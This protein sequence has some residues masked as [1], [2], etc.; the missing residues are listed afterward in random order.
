M[1]AKESAPGH[2]FLSYVREDLH[3]VDALQRVLEAAQIRVWRDT[4]DLWPGQDWRREIR[5]A[6]TD[7]ALVFIACFSRHSIGREKSYMNEELKLAI[8]QLKQRRLDSSWLIPVRLDDSMIP[9]WDIGGDQ[10]LRSIQWIDLFGDRDREGVARLVATVTRILGNRTDAAVAGRRQQDTKADLKPRLEGLTDGQDSRAR[11]RGAPANRGTEA[12]QFAVGLAE[13]LPGVLDEIEALGTPSRIRKLRIPTGHRGLD[14]LFGGWPRG[15]LITVS[16]RPSSGKSTLLLG[17]CR[18]ASI[19]YRI[20]SML[21]TTEMNDRELQIRLLSAEARVPSHA[22]RISQLDDDN[23]SRLSG[24]MK[25]VADV[26]IFISTANVFDFDLLEREVSN[27]VERSSLRLLVLD[28]LESAIE[29]RPKGRLSIEFHLQRLKTLAEKLK[30]SIIASV[31]ANS[32]RDL[33]RPVE[34]ND[35]RDKNAVENISDIIILIE[36]PDQYDYE[37]PRAGEADFIVV[38]N[39]YGPTRTVSVAYQGHYSRFVD[40]YSPEPQP[41]SLFQ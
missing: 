5:R 8:E 33:F 3:A 19:N 28:G 17:F 27:A 38:K 14:S 13:L 36:R 15:A 23:W 25:A 31:Q 40:M 1:N 37:S 11:L 35:V 32:P 20:P 41:P 12:A 34:L 6:I 26:P 4:D 39:R 29:A 16:G 21:I 2:V 30:I 24:A 9:D 22:I 7:H 18:A 10:T